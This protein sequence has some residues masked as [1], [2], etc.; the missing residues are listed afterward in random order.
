MEVGY[1]VGYVEK[2]GKDYDFHIVNTVLYNKDDLIRVTKEE[3]QKHYR[4]LQ[5]NATD[6]IYMIFGNEFDEK[7]EDGCIA[8]YYIQEVRSN[9]LVI[10]FKIFEMSDFLGGVDFE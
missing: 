6:E 8:E 5:D 3:L 9:Y 2:S 7:D 10:K 4:L 1:I